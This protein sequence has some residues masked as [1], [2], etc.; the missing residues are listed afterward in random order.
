MKTLDQYLTD[1]GLSD[2]GFGEQIG[3]TGM[4]VGRYRRGLAIPR[5][6]VMENIY[7]ETG[8]VVPPNSFYS[9]TFRKPR[10][11]LRRKAGWNGGRGTQKA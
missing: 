9:F 11:R 8:G 7:D 1:K 5:E 4:Q 2:E 10:R 6:E 3:K